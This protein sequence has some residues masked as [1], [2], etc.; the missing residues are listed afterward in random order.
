M[1]YGRTT[2]IYPGQST[3][4]SQKENAPEGD[5]DCGGKMEWRKM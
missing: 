1:S 4:V 2:M 3:S 5:P